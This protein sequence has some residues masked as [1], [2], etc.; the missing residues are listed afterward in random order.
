V[1]INQALFSIK[2][3]TKQSTSFSIKLLGSIPLSGFT[4]IPSVT[5]FQFKK[6]IQEEKERYKKY[7]LYFYYSQLGYISAAC[8]MRPTDKKLKD[9]HYPIPAL[10][11][12]PVY[13]FVSATSVPAAFL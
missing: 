6:V 13:A 7:G 9:F 5:P 8:P 11:P 10:T 2:R 1:E 3:A 4:P 12:A